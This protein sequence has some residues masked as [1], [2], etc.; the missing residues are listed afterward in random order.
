MDG[1]TNFWRRPKQFDDLTWVILTPLF[2]ERSTPL[3]V[4]R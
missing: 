1:K 3:P 2:Y 4:C